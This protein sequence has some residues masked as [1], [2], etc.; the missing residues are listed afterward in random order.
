MSLTEW[1]PAEV[2]ALGEDRIL[3]LMQNELAMSY[4]TDSKGIRRVIPAGTEFTVH[5]GTSGMEVRDSHLGRQVYVAVYS[6]PDA[7]LDDILA[8]SPEWT[9]ASGGPDAFVDL[10]A[11]R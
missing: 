3:S 8:D 2:I 9:P 10:G 11:A 5:K 1:L 4:A 6:G 7:D